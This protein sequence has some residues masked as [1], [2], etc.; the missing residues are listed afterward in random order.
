MHKDAGDLIREIT[1]KEAEKHKKQREGRLEKH[2]SEIKVKYERVA[3][4]PLYF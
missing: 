4:L 1:V 3:S 2:N